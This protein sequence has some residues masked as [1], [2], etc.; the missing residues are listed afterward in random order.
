MEIIK[1]LL[2]SMALAKD[3][4]DTHKN[5]AAPFPRKAIGRVKE[6]SKPWKQPQAEQNILRGFL[7]RNRYWFDNIPREMSGQRSDITF[8]A[9]L[10][11]DWCQLHAFFAQSFGISLWIASD[12][13]LF[14][15]ADI[16]WTRF[17]SPIIYR[18][19]TLS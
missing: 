7:A 10:L 8:P 19:L 3:P 13:P 15:D 18:V 2:F 11:A 6:L 16:S 14:H 4:S 9:S 1:I 12:S 5:A 17:G